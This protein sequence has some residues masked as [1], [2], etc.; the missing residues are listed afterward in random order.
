MF[1]VWGLENIFCCKVPGRGTHGEARL[2]AVAN[3]WN[4]WVLGYGKDRQTRLLSRL[5]MGKV[6]WQQLTLILMLC[7]AVATALLSLSLLREI[8]FRRPAEEVRH[9]R[10]F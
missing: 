10:R 6:N 1:V 9:Y 4:Q 5:G 7:A 8:H 3:G 2:D